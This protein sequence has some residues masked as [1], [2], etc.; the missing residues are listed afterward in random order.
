MSNIQ[1][2]LD[3]MSSRRGRVTYSMSYRNGPNSYD[4]SSAVFY[5][6]QAGGFSIPFIGNTETLFSMRGGLLSPISRS[7]VRS[8]DIFVSGVPGGSANAY[9]HTGFALNAT[10]AIHCS[11]TFNGIGISSNADSAVRA[12]GGAPV[13]WFRVAGSSAPSPTPENPDEDLITIESVNDGKL[14]VDNEFLIDH[15]GIRMGTQTFDDVEDAFD[16]MQK[17]IEFMND[18]PLD[19]HE[20]RLTRA[21]L[22]LVDIRYS[23]VKVG[24]VVNVQNPYMQLEPRMRIEEKQINIINPHT[25]DLAVG[26]KFDD[27]TDYYL[28]GIKW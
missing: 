17:G 7:D 25:S 26:R 12:Y 11:S 21:N 28:G 6:L 3:W 13:Y 14:Y 16:T 4:C 10:Q 15:F 22:E 1:A 9:G 19:W 23:T 24:D 18:Q 27:F 20:I 8:G 5:A 2:T